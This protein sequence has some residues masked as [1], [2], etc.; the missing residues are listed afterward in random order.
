VVQGIR[1]GQDLTSRVG[2]EN[3]PNDEVHQLSNIFDEMLNRL[4]AS[5]ENEKQFIFDASHELKTPIA[6]II[7]YCEYLLSQD[8]LSEKAREEIGTILQQAK[9]MSRLI[10]QLLLLSKAEYILQIERVNMSD[11]LEVIVEEQQIF[12]EEKGITLHTDIAKDLLIEAD[13]TMMIRVFINLLKNAITYGK[14]DGNIY[15]ELKEDENCLHGTLRD[16]G[17]G[18][19]AEHLEKIW[20]RFYQVETSRNTKKTSGMG[21]GLSMVKWIVEAHHGSIKVE[22]TWGEGTTFSFIFPKK[23]EK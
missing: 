12:A 20:N 2:L 10:S 14:A 6:V 8:N 22:S 15:I 19:R 4:Q 11:L 17:I 18:I 7:S 9:K 3:R 5:F 21:L 1:K 13:E 16:D 23:M